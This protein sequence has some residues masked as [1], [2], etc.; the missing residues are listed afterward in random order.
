MK[1]WR[2]RLRF[3]PLHGTGSSLRFTLCVKSPQSLHSDSPDWRALQWMKRFTWLQWMKSDTSAMY[4]YRNNRV[5]I[6]FKP[7][8]NGCPNTIRYN[9]VIFM[10]KNCSLK[11]LLL[12]VNLYHVQQ[13]YVFVCWEI[14]SVQ[15]NLY[16][17]DIVSP[18]ISAILLR[19][20]WKCCIECIRGYKFS[21]SNKPFKEQ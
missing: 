3:T 8:C 16:F 20:H 7:Q 12:Q 1:K 13:F 6:C 15:R 17:H 4:T 19:L 18:S 5:V 11:G 14:R 10:Y 9:V 2:D 21:W